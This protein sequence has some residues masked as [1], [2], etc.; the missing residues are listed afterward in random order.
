MPYKVSVLIKR[1]AAKV[2]SVGGALTLLLDLA[3]PIAPFSSYIL[4]VSIVAL[5]ICFIMISYG[6]FSR[7]A[8][9]GATWFMSLA[10][11]AGV[12]YALQ[13]AVP[14]GE[15]KGFLA[16][17]VPPME[18][19]QSA[20]LG[21]HTSTREISKNT[22]RTAEAVEN[23]AVI[24]RELKKET[25]DNPRKEL[26]NLGIEWN[27]FSF[28]YALRQGDIHAAELFIQSGMKPKEGF[29]R[30][31]LD[32]DMGARSG[33][34]DPKSLDLLKQ[35]GLLRLGSLCE[36][37]LSWPL[38]DSIYY[39][40]LSCLMDTCS[41]I[42]RERNRRIDFVLKECGDGI[43][44]KMEDTADEATSKGLSINP[45]SVILAFKAHPISVSY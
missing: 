21:I 4:A 40:T 8:A 27:Y 28:L 36:P 9:L 11:L 44:S 38:Y 20:L 34:P 33:M 39:D 42:R 16:A 45:G 35:R 3:Q 30:S 31:L 23:I 13:E 19:I 12:A 6:F 2:F 22:E 10:I 43:I 18:G 14:S 26:A 41:V 17:T 1:N 7:L 32:N 37:E 5:P 15:K 24:N 25:S 29:V